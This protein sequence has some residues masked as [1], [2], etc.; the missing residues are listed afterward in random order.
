MELILENVRCFVRKH[1]IPVKPLTILIGE[2]STGKTTFLA[3]LAI[4]CNTRDLLEAPNFNES[5]YSLGTFDTIA[6]SS[7]GNQN[8]AKYFSLGCTYKKEMSDGTTQV[9][10]T[11]RNNR[12]QIE[13]FKLRGEVANNSL[14]IWLDEVNKK[15]K[16]EYK[17]GNEKNTGEYSIE[18][19]LFDSS[20]LVALSVL[21]IDLLPVVKTLS[22]API[23]TKPE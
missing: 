10:A 16:Y 6:S 8:R 20:Y 23:R 19:R 21:I 18:R 5:P 22:I 3:A 13:L 7:N 15:Y 14:K 1:T 4:V 2:N 12:G 17:L 9:L 11:F